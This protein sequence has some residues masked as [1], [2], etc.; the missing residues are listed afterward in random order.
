MKVRFKENPHKKL[1]QH[2]NS[3]SH[4]EA[5]VTMTNLKIDWTLNKANQ[6]T[7]D[8]KRQANE[9]YIEKLLR[10]IH[11]LA[12]NNLVVKR[13]YPKVTSFLENEQQ[14]PIMKQYLE[15]FPKKC[16][17]WFLRLMQ[18]ALIN[19]LNLHLK[20]YKDAYGSRWHHNFCWW[21]YFFS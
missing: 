5:V 6:N 8:E 4:K 15:K 13:L 20:I 7:R 2:D 14:E 12:R 16:S 11:F 18:C 17:V 19:S 3:D 21:S 9:L 10:I 1:K